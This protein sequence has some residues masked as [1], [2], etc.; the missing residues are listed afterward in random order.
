V[1]TAKV[2]FAIVQLDKAVKQ[3]AEWVVTQVAPSLA[4]LA[5][6]DPGNIK[7][8]L[9]RVIDD[10]FGHL[11]LYRREKATRFKDLGFTLG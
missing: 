7:N 8:W 5:M 6:A 2:S 1:V 11:D 3:V 10:G 9:H 4:M